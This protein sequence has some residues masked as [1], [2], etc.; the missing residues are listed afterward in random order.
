MVGAVVVAGN[1]HLQDANVVSL[2]VD[3]RFRRMGVARQLLSHALREQSPEIRTVSLEVR[4]DNSGARALYE[5][6][7][8]RVIRRIRRYYP[9]GT[10]GLQYRAPLQ[11][12]IAAAQAS[13][14][15]DR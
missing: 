13:R 6:L 12:V 9:D 15:T 10:T 8:F 2:A 11:D 4:E 5:R 7:G 3:R 14:T 1:P